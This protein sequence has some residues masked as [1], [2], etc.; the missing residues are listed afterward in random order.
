MQCLLPSK[1]RRQKKWRKKS[2]ERSGVEHAGLFVSAL[3]VVAAADERKGQSTKTYEW[4]SGLL[5]RT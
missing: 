5:E 4:L 2:F 3:L 1:A